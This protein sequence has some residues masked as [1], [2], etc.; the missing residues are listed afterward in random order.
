M[1]KKPCDA[2]EAKAFQNRIVKTQTL[3]EMLTVHYNQMETLIAT[4]LVAL[5]TAIPA[6]QQG[7]QYG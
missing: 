5:Q 4:R 2:F 1:S 3:A 7:T 6:E